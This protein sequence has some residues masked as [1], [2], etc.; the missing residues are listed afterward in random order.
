MILKVLGFVDI[1]VV[2]GGGAKNVDLGDISMED[3]VGRLDMRLREK[4]LA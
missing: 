4:V 1:T 2:A 3:F